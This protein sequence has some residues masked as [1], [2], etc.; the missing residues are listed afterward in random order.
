MSLLVF[1]RTKYSEV[2]N[3]DLSFFLTKFYPLQSHRNRCIKALSISITT[4]ILGLYLGNSKLDDSEILPLVVHSSA[5]FFAILATFAS[6]CALCTISMKK[7]DP[8]L[9]LTA[10]L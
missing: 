1:A 2:V 5:I 3:Q 6:F 9:F 4:L 8:H 7:E 10:Y